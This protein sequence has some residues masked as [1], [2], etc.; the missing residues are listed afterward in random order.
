LAS[1]VSTIGGTSFPIGLVA[2]TIGSR[3]FQLESIGEDHWLQLFR[4]LV[5]LVSSW[6]WSKR[7]LGFLGSFNWDLYRLSRMVSRPYWSLIGAPIGPLLVPLL[8]PYW[9]PYWSLIGA[10]IG[11]LMPCLLVPYWCPYWSLNALPIGPLLVPLLVP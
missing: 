5:A 2:R 8:V 1:A 9:C 11:P 7:C 3:S 6:N 4:L 10:P